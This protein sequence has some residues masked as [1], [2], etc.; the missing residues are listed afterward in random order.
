LHSTNGIVAK[1]R[2]W[3]GARWDCAASQWRTQARRKTHE[4]STFIPTW[5]YLTQDRRILFVSK[6]EIRTKACCLTAHNPSIGR[7]WS[8]SSKLGAWCWAF[9]VPNWSMSCVEN[10]RL[11]S[12][13]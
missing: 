8:A 5:N 9:C 7:S 1:A 13:E 3:A 10:R 6:L 11:F 2:T 4:K 12:V